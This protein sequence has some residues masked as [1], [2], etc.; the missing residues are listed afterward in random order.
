MIP[1]R[2]ETLY[3]EGL[4]GSSP[5]Q[6]R[7]S[8]KPALPLPKGTAEDHG[9][10]PLRA[11]APHILASN[12][13][14]RSKDSPVPEVVSLANGTPAA[15]PFGP[16][17][18]LRT[19]TYQGGDLSRAVASRARPLIL[20]DTAAKDRLLAVT[21]YGPFHDLPS[22]FAPLP[23]RSGF[24]GRPSFSGSISTSGDSG[25]KCGVL[26]MPV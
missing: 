18:N 23:R 13:L 21:P 19:Q 26:E 16:R 10:G 25:R 14:F 24:F 7:R 6:E 17:A 1:R 11:P 9:R 5:L 4:P 20:R 2:G 3:L 12:R 22:P 8:P 15:G